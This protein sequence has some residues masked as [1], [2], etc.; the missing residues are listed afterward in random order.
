MAGKK[1]VIE[2]GV[3]KLVRLVSEAKKISVKEAAKELG[4]SVSSIEEW[5]DFLEEEGIINIQSQFTTVYLVEK[6]MGK[7]EL[8]EKVK[9]VKGEKEDFVRRVDS[10]INALQRDHEEIK[11]IDSEFRKIRDLLE[12]NFEKLNKKLNALEDFKKSHHEIERKKREIEEEYEGKILKLESNLKNEQKDYEKVM[13][14]VETELE[15]IKKEREKI[16]SLKDS[17]KKMGAKVA[18]INRMIE[19]IKKEIEHENDQL[20]LDDERLDKSEESAKRIKAELDASHKEI[21]H[22]TDKIKASRKEFEKMEKELVRDLESLG[23]G[24]L[25]KISSYK[26]SKQVV[27]K[28]KQFFR[29]T[30]E[31][32]ALIHKA[33]KE[34]SD[35]RDHFEKL[36]KKVQA[37]RVI[38][39]VPE[40]KKE[41]VSLHKEL[42]EIEERKA[43]LATQLKKL[44]NAMRSVVH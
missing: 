25:E 17:E 21:S 5:A 34:E 44:R 36:A 3:D 15:T 29:Q 32:E 18:E 38:T 33:E 13:A 37:F 11:L 40:V 1:S 14:A 10:S 23:K 24:Q 41:M 19:Q 4:V 20:D 26:E 8:I 42:V 16:D 28:F 6:K 31:V 27:D 39:T 22:V 43:L 30:D 2:T 12:N 9:A 7:R 35:I